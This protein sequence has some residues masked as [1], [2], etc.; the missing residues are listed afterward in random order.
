MNIIATGF[1]KG[2]FFEFLASRIVVHI[3]EN[4]MDISFSSKDILDFVAIYF[5]RLIASSF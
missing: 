1:E 4:R 3:T 5:Y 2:T